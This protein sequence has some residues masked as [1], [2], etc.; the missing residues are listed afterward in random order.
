MAS[1]Q[2]NT[3][4]DMVERFGEES[5]HT[6][7]RRTAIPFGSPKTPGNKDLGPKSTMSRLATKMDDLKLSS[8]RQPRTIPSGAKHLLLHGERE[9]SKAERKS[10]AFGCGENGLALEDCGVAGL[11]KHVLGGRTWSERAPD[12]SD[13]D[14]DAQP[15]VQVYKKSRVGRSNSSMKAEAASPPDFAA[16]DA[17]E[18]SPITTAAV[19]PVPNHSRFRRM[20]PLASTKTD[21]ENDHEDEYDESSQISS[22]TGKAGA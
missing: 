16:L 13:S 12:V 15:V 14:P 5:F 8:G 19:S 2:P 9:A 10:R 3:P 21:D 20:R 7:P 22:N 6:P 17:L 1:S 11:P 18:L 4:S